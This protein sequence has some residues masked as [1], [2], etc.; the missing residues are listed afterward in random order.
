MPVAVQP[1]FRLARFDRPI[2]TWLLFWPCI[3]SLLLA[4][5][6]GID[7]Q[8]VL[9]FSLLFFIGA[10]VMRGAGCAYNDI[11]DRDIDAKVA[12]SRGRPLP[13]GQVTVRQAWIFLGALCLVGLGVLV[14]FNVPT[15]FMALGA[16]VLVA[17]YPFMKRITWWPQ[18]WLGL[19]FNWG[20]LV[21]W[22]AVTGQIEA[23][24]VLVYAAGVFWTLGYDTIYA[25]QDI[26]DDVLAGVKSS[27][28]AL[29]VNTIRRSV[30]IFYAAALGLLGSALY[31]LEANM[32][33][34]A[35][36]VP[37]GGHFALQVFRLDASN[38]KICLNLFKANRDTGAL[39]ALACLGCLVI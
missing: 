31:V 9:W 21:G 33:H 24:A 12:R 30:A 18:A 38:G 36:L 34:V 15:I 22:M 27:A 14:Q 20:A 39:I 4:Q 5:G 10:T 37:A 28:R 19:T 26:E 1:Y 17:V 35:L 3:W 32:L 29:G 16:L 7:W 6:R 13:S 25:A 8:L 2:G 11:V 23:G